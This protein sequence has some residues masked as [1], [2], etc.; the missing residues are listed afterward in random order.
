MK[1]YGLSASHRVTRPFWPYPYSISSRRLGLPSS[2]SRSPSPSCSG[3]KHTTSGEFLSGHFWY[4]KPFVAIHITS[5]GY[6]PCDEILQSIAIWNISNHHGLPVPR[7]EFL[8]LLI[9]FP[10]VGFTHVVSSSTVCSYTSTQQGLPSWAGL[11]S[12]FY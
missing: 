9:W 8:A 2:V 11:P 4:E 1:S 6:L 7:V 10:G 5:N 12:V 3:G